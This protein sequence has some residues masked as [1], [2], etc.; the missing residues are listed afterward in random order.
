MS[1]V[2]PYSERAALSKFNRVLCTPVSD[3][4]RGRIGPRPPAVR[5][6][7]REIIEAA[8]LPAVLAGRVSR[9]VHATRLWSR[10]KVQVA[11][12]LVAH[13]Q[14]G[15]EAGRGESELLDS[16]GDERQVASLIRRA[17]LR[18][19]PAI[20]KLTHASTRVLQFV[21]ALVVL[22]YAVQA[23]RL[24]GRSPNVVR[25]FLAEWNAAP[26]LVPE[27]ERAWPV[28][29]A[30]V[31]QRHSELPTYES[32]DVNP[33]S[34]RWGE[35]AA[36]VAENAAALEL[37]RRAA[38]MPKL[39]AVLEAKPDDE[40]IQR[41][42]FIGPN[43]FSSTPENPIFV[44]VWT[45]QGAVLR[46]AARLLMLDARVAAIDGD[47]ERCAADI[48]AMI[49][50]AE[51]TFQLRLPIGDL[52]GLAIGS[53][54]CRVAQSV[55]HRHPGLLSDTQL[56]RL[57]HRLAVL[58]GGGEVRLNL[59][60]EY[61]MCEDIL[62]RFYTD[63][64]HGG[65][66]PTPE[67]LSVALAATRIQQR[68]PRVPSWA[69]APAV[70]TIL[71]G[72]RETEARFRALLARIEAEARTPLWARGPS[73]VE[74]ELQEL[75][76][77]PLRRLRSFPVSEFVRPYSDAFRSSEY[78]MQARDAALVAIALELYRRRTAAWP[79]A[80]DELTPQF[81]PQVPLD[82]Y[83]GEPI[84]YRLVDGQPLVY[85]VGV[86]RSDD[87]GRLPEARGPDDTRVERNARA[88][89]W[90]P[91]VTPEPSADALPVELLPDGD[92]ILWPPI[93]R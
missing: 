71:S 54:A 83:D 70:S 11:R 3:L 67:M 16:F 57:S 14:D 73:E 64:G 26:L 88:R 89:N 49:G 86:N 93:E 33:A 12:E 45:P 23:L 87:G 29:Q 61:A 59:A 52:V 34:S 10:E 22:V 40:W 37:Y 68:L 53:Q 1:V 27:A 46:E 77:F 80:L 28:Y 19:R 91:P 35:L 32:S 42:Y 39:G 9:V 13:F 18:N 79:A 6:G 4:L 30:A 31:L 63:D 48:E 66:Q 5:V 62:Q 7:W 24:Y 50:A 58:G 76:S 47:S 25:N 82:R 8:G 55:L 56:A 72:R 51:H 20:W 78:F 60:S 21:F 74:R 90:K 15:L 41:L 36:C 38:S 2:T 65:G 84:K 17:K 75:Y 92:W 85:S 43:S 44:S 81:L 69:V